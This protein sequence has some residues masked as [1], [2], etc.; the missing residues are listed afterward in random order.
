M[1][2]LFLEVEGKG[3]ASAVSRYTLGDHS[4]AFVIQ[5]LIALPGV[6]NVGTERFLE[7]IYPDVLD[8]VL[9]RV[10]SERKCVLCCGEMECVDFL[11]VAYVE[12]CRVCNGYQR[13]G[14]NT[15]VPDAALF[16]HTADAEPS[17]AVASEI[18]GLGRLD[19]GDV[20]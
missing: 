2:E 20:K 5:P 12:F 10:I 14:C 9:L 11:H 8:D 6:E 18:F 19:R 13:E 3:V 1:R 15:L 7:L 4:L 17:G 16:S